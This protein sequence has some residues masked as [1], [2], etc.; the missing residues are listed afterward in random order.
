[1]PI[2]ISAQVYDFTLIKSCFPQLNFPIKEGVNNEQTYKNAVLKG[3]FS[4]INFAKNSLGLQ[5]E[6][7]IRFEIYE[8]F[9]GKVLVLTMLLPKNRTTF[10]EDLRYNY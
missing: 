4:D 7:E 6:S 9:A 2:K 8:S 10:L 1:M 3:D 5:G